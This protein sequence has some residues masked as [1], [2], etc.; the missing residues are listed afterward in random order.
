MPFLPKTSVRH[1]KI[2]R[3]CKNKKKV[4]CKHIAKKM[5][6]TKTVKKVRK[7]VKKS[8]PAETPAPP[9]P[10]PVVEAKKTTKKTTKKATTTATP[11]PETVPA[12]SA[13]AEKKPRKPRAKKEDASAS[14]SASAEA[15]KAESETKTGGKK[16]VKRVF[17]VLSVRD[18]EGKE[19]DFKGGK[20]FSK[21]PAGAARKSAN[22]ACKILYNDQDCIVEVLI[23]EITKNGSSKEYSY[24]A[25][26]K[27]A[28]K[29]VP[30]QGSSGAVSIPFKYSMVLKSLKTEKGKKVATVVPQS[31]LDTVDESVA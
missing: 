30:F 11:A 20:Y 3:T 1:S 31:E 24:R 9:A 26:R 10:E 28:E 2:N 4:N 27:L 23:K 21:T 12:E 15:V 16:V 22:Q 19:C 13:K 25:E 8:D 6:D 29:T 18:I 14:P 17:T 7:V 5:S